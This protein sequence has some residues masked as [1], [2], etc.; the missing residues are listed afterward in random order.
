MHEKQIRREEAARK[1]KELL[2]S[3]LEKDPLQAGSP[4]ETL[5]HR[6]RVAFGPD[7]W[8]ASREMAGMLYVFLI[9]L[10]LAI[11][12]TVLW[13]FYRPWQA[14][15]PVE[16]EISERVLPAGSLQRA[17]VSTGAQQHRAAAGHDLADFG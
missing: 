14:V 17:S 8:T 9:L 16:P 6:E 15:H 4:P 12:A 11:G 1:H 13:L 2:D 10:I 3:H 5:A 7:K